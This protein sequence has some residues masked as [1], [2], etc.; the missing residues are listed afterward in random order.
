MT[1]LRQIML[2]ELR[3]R[4]YA[5]ST[6]RT[7]IRTVEHFSRYFHRPPDQLGPRTYSRVSSRIVH[8]V[9]IGSEH[10]D[11]AVGSPAFLL[12]P[13]VEARLE[14]CRDAVSEEGSALTAGTQPGRSGASD[15]RGRVSPSS[16]PADDSLCHGRTPRRSGAPR[17]SATSTANAW[18][19]TSGEARAARTV[20]SCS[21][22]SCSMHCA[23]TGAGCGASLPTGL[24]QGFAPVMNRHRPLLGRLP[25][26]ARYSSF[27]AA[28]SLGNP[29]RVLMI[30][31][32]DLFSD[33]TLLVV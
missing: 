3:R 17:R 8:A 16:H 7:Y 25:H 26:S 19:F 11:A 32:S 23:S 4:N 10:R 22:R 9:E 15:R 28:S 30:L 5:E 2:E 29:P 33:S 14:R 31:R 12:C 27:N 13:G 1:H 20:T 24:V 21:A 18:S 6:I